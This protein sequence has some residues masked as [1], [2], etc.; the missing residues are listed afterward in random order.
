MLKNIL[1]LQLILSK[2]AKKKEEAKADTEDDTE[3]SANGEDEED[4]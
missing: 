1:I 4:V 2:N 3:K